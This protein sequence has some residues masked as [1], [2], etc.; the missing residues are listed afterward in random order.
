MGHFISTGQEWFAR[1]FHVYFVS[2][3]ETRLYCVKRFF[4]IALMRF[5]WLAMP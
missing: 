4:K 2:L 3:Y 5:P 1:V